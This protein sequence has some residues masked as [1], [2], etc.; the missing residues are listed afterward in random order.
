M[1]NSTR[2]DPI[3]TTIAAETKLPRNTFRRRSNRRLPLHPPRRLRPRRP[4][5][6]PL[7]LDRPRHGPNRRLGNSTPL[8]H[9]VVRKTHPLL[10]GR[11]HRLHDASPCRMGRTPALRHRRPSH[12]TRPSLARQRILRAVANEPRP[13]R[14][15]RESGP[16]RP[17][18]FLHHRS[19]HRLRPRRHSRHALQRLNHSRHGRGSH[20]DAQCR[21]SALRRNSLNTKK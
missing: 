6:T 3:A 17:N 16:T 9:S 21:R 15:F 11:R 1:L 4:R 20:R 10:L 13:R 14:Q 2:L 18:H 5:R 19:R 7:R 12:S 8:R